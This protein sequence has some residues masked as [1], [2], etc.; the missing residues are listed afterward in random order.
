[1]G[2]IKVKRE[3]KTEIK[4]EE[5]KKMETK[6]G[7]IT[8]MGKMSPSGDVVLLLDNTQEKNITTEKIDTKGLLGKKVELQMVDETHFQGWKIVDKV[9]DPQEEMVM[10][11]AKPEP[12]EEVKVESEIK[13]DL[14]KETGE[15]PIVEPEPEEVKE[16]EKPDTTLEEERKETPAEPEPEK[17]MPKPEMI[18][19]KCKVFDT[20]LTRFC[21]GKIPIILN[22]MENA[23][24]IIFVGKDYI[25]FEI[26]REDIK[27]KKKN[28]PET[29]K[30]EEYKE[31][32]IYKET[33]FIPFKDIT[34]ISTG[35][36]E[37][38]KPE[39]D[40]GLADI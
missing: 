34:L 31:T 23:G 1:M 26:I 29:K 10:E 13:A 11:E 17:V 24:R 2:R 20:L 27:S 36:N 22:G 28:N 39:E 33:I 25:E 12:K 32:K 35:E 30:R 3:S 6:T 9:S 8:A 4:N 40:E 37:V 7:I 38:A 18:E 15:V 5:L 14:E 16:E 19:Q 21:S